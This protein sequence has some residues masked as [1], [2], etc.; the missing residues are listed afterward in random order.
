[1][2]REVKNLPKA[3]QLGSVSI[4]TLD[5]AKTR[6]FAFPSV[7]GPATLTARVIKSRRHLS[8]HVPPG[9]DIPNNQPGKQEGAFEGRAVG[10]PGF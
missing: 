8:P 4:W 9:G 10:I 3:A 5:L 6:D 7:A 1:M 2:P